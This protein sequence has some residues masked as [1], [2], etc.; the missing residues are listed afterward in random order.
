MLTAANIKRVELFIS[1]VI[2]SL[3]G[4]LLFRPALAAA[5]PVTCPDGF[6]TSASTPDGAVAACANHQT[7]GPEADDAPGSTTLTGDCTDQD[8]TKNCGIVGYLLLTINILSGIV[9]VVVIAMMIAGGIQYSSAGGDPGKVVAAKKRIG[10]ALLALVAYIFL[11]AFL[12][13]IVPGGIF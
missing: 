2:L 5:F 7:G 8:L 12:Q 10:N 13:W 1:L 9:G 6:Q 11:Y 3:I 4:F